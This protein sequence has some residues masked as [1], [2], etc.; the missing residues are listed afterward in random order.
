MLRWQSVIMECEK[1]GTLAELCPILLREYPAN[2]KL[3]EAVAPW[4]PNISGGA[5]ETAPETAPKGKPVVKV[6]IVVDPIYA[7]DA[8]TIFV[9]LDSMRADLATLAKQMD[10]QRRWRKEI[11]M[12]AAKDQAGERE[13]EIPMD[14]SL[15]LSKSPAP[16]GTENEEK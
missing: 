13:T 7:D 9:T 11:A 16:G 2:T 15:P 8:E 5:P 3:A 10:E 4:M 12:L 6:P 1:Q 14:I